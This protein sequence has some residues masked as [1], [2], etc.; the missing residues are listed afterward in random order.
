MNIEDV[1]S[2]KRRIKILRLL[3]EVRELN[4]SAIA[5]RLS[6]NYEDTK[7]HLRILEDEGFLKRKTFGKASFY[8][9]S[10]Q[11]QK[12]TLIRSLIVAWDKEKQMQAE[13][14]S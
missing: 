12:A 10:E 7:R 6:A 11:S 3:T 14:V 13:A 9:F 2:S 5:S 4:V 8:R 1:L